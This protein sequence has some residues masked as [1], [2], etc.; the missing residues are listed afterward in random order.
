MQ[1]PVPSTLHSFC[2]KEIVFLAQLKEEKK[3]THQAQPP[4]SNV[5]W[6]INLIDSAEPVLIRFCPEAEK[7]MLWKG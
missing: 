7:C 2:I 3:K 6:T 4:E 1:S 5:I